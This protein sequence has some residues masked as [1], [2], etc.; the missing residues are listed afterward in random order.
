VPFERLACR[1]RQLAGQVIADEIGKLATGHLRV[2]ALF[3]AARG[4]R[5]QHACRT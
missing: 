1:G 4:R 5:L 2:L 3:D